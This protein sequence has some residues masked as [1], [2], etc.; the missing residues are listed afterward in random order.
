MQA[1]VKNYTVP[2]LMLIL[3]ITSN[4]MKRDFSIGVI[5][6]GKNGY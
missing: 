6:M 1:T 4:M 2:L 5:F 3:D